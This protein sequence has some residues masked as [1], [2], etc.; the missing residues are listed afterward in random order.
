MLSPKELYELY[1]LF[2]CTVSLPSPYS[3][4][5]SDVVYNKLSGGF[6]TFVPN[7]AIGTPVN[8]LRTINFFKNLKYPCLENAPNIDQIRN[9]GQNKLCLSFRF[10]QKMDIEAYEERQPT[11]RSGTA[12]SVRNSCDLSRA[13]YLISQGN[14]KS[15]YA[16]MATEYIEYFAHNSLPDCLMMCGPDLIDPVITEYYRAPGMKVKESEPYTISGASSY[17]LDGE[18]LDRAVRQDVG[19]LCFPKSGKDGVAGAEHFCGPTIPLPCKTDCKCISC[20]GCPVDSEG[21]VIDPDLPCCRPGTIY[22]ANECCN[23]AKKSVTNRVKDFSLW[24]KSDDGSFDGTILRGRVGEKLKHIGI[25]ERKLYS[26][27]ANF[28]NQ[29]SAE[30]PP[31][32]IDDVFFD[33]FQSINGWD[34]KTNTNLT[35]S[36]PQIYR[37][38]TISLILRATVQSPSNIAT[39]TTWMIQ[40]IKDL[41]WNGYGVLL[42][43]NIGFPNTRDS[44]GVS[45][46]DR[47]FYQ[48]YSIIG[49]D[50][51][52]TLY[53]ECVYVLHCPFGDWNSG[54]HPEWGPLPKGCFLVTESHLKCIISYFPTSDF[55]RCVDCGS[56]SLGACEPFDCRPQQRA[57]GFLFAISLQEGFPKQELDHSQ[58][59]PIQSLK[60]ILKE[61]KLYYKPENI[62]AELELCN[63]NHLWKDVLATKKAKII[64]KNNQDF[65]C[66]LNNNS[67]IS[68]NLNAS[69]INCLENIGSLTINQQENS[70]FNVFLRPNQKNTIAEI[71][72]RPSTSLNISTTEETTDTSFYSSRI[73]SYNCNI[74]GSLSIQL[75]NLSIDNNLTLSNISG[76]INR[77]IQIGFGQVVC[78]NIALSNSTLDTNNI[79]L[80]DARFI[81]SYIL[82]RN[83][84]NINNAENNSLYT[85]TVISGN[86]VNVNNFQTFILPI[87]GKESV[88]INNTDYV[89]GFVDS[90]RINFT[91]VYV[92]SAI[93]TKN[94]IAMSI[95]TA[96]ARPN[97]LKPIPYDGRPQVNQYLDPSGSIKIQG[98]DNEDNQAV[99]TPLCSIVSK[100]IVLD[101]YINYGTIIGERITLGN[102]INYGSIQ[103]RFIDNQNTIN[104]GSIIN[105]T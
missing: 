90:P 29:C 91:N 59:Y 73:N 79:S 78:D 81:D 61:Q 22:H 1:S 64:S 87:I 60:E 80:T 84:I 68:L 9:T 67:E 21:K 56:S 58:F 28:T 42:L 89:L 8:W 93:Q 62:T 11:T 105:I 55:Y 37:A 49:Y 16:R 38:R 50:D 100:N 94:N 4:L 70:V 104:N 101:N 10:L 72:C 27:Y 92:I 45:F 40:Q 66:L 97:P 47:I 13:C 3:Q 41:L 17:D 51:T 74:N 52:R 36:D 24:V 75:F 39:D 96:S 86:I 63:I 30:K 33:H 98:L 6:L 2:P 31:I 57:F 99:L 20:D 35:L 88:S 46:P 26:G 83:T 54:G 44:T 77:T 103:G 43:T 14:E 71:I 85:N 53:N 34:Y 65:V 82:S 95:E 19:M 7:V 48:T 76:T 18:I 32:C 12:H 15:W 5:D 25:L 102:G 23:I 69:N